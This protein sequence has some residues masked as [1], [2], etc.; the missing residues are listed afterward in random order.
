MKNASKLFGAIAVLLSTAVNASPEA[1]GW[2]QRMDNAVRHSDYEGRFV[3]QVGDQLDAMY[4]V[5]RR[6]ADT[7]FE[8]LISLNG[9]AKQIIRGDEGVACLAP[10]KH[11]ISVIGSASRHISQYTD[12]DY[13]N[14]SRHYHFAMGP[15]QRVAGR[16]A[17]IIEV[18]PRDKLRFGYRLYLDL[19]TG[20]PLRS[21]MLDVEGNQRSQMMFV[22]L[23]ADQQITPIEQ[24]LAALALAEPAPEKQLHGLA[25]KA[26][27]AWQFNNLPAGFQLRQYRHL[28]GESREHFMFTD[29]LATISLYVEPFDG[30]PLSGYSQLGAASL[31]GVPLFD[32]QVT[33]LGEVPLTTLR[34]LAQS[35]QPA[36]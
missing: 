4:V 7:E 14:L 28:A 35:I 6:H 27:P 5:H 31:F 19:R 8:R 23:K 21:V 32:H 10:Q 15:L 33:V 34:R 22:S 30:E 36:K 24:D 11:Q 25:D 2:F 9:E 20:L 13:Q 12:T 18:A 17:Q 26:E 29:G 3:Y 16:E 1:F